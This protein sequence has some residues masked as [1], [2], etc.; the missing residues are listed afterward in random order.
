VTRPDTG[1]DTLADII[2][3][4]YELG[5]VE[6]PEPLPRA[7]QRRHR[8]LLVRTS[9]GVYLAKTYHNRPEVVDSLHFQH[10]LSDHLAAHGIPVARIQPAVSGKRIVQVDDWILE[11]QAYV[12][13]ELME[14][15]SDSLA[16][17]ADALGRFH[18][19]CRDFPRP[20]RDAR[21][22]RFS[23]VS[24]AS[25]ANLYEAA[26]GEAGAEYMADLC[27]RI[28]VFLRDAAQALDWDKRSVFET[29]LIH[30]DWHSGNLIFQEGR[31]AAVVDLE[32]A[33]DGC[34]L[35]DLAYA[36]S[37]LCLRTSVKT[38]RLAKRTDI[39][40]KHYQAHRELAYAEE[41]ALYY[42]VGIKHVATVS[43]QVEQLGGKVAGYGPAQ[44]MV[45]L[46]AQCEWLAQRAHEAR[47]RG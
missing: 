31:L 43:Y 28:A 42:A 10:H 36:M 24:R 46:A 2:R 25:F 18:E 7:H 44:W 3:R 35:E 29:G 8:K 30:G 12:D 15:N 17:S 20:P 23:E 26:R 47:W 21:M 37:N 14:V 32:F 39:L 19:V 33:G 11:L 38:E 34:F 45:R 6:R 9:S 22:W 40:L 13:G 41:V 27:N 5:E 16:Q 4:Q 1:L